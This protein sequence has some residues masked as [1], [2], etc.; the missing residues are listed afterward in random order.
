MPDRL[1]GADRL[2]ERRFSLLGIGDRVFERAAGDSTLIAAA[3]DRPDVQRAQQVETAALLPDQV[4]RRRDRPVEENLDRCRPPS[5]RRDGR[6]E[7]SRPLVWSERRSARSRARRSGG[8][9]GSVRRDG[10]D[11]VARWAMLVQ[12]LT[13]DDPIVAVASRPGSKRQRVGTAARLTDAEGEDLFP[14]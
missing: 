11:V 7:R 8:S 4:P 9:G 10:D 5:C 2:A 13:V 3:E 14:R 6:G 12:S 1:K